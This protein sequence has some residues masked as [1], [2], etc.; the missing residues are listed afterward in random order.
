MIGMWEEEVDVIR[1]YKLIIP[2]LE[3][4]LKYMASKPFIMALETCGNECF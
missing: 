3:L 4:I 1:L 2:C